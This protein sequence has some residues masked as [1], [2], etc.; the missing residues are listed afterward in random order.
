[1]IEKVEALKAEVEHEKE[2]L[3]NDIMEF[4]SY[5]QIEKWKEKVFS[6]QEELKYLRIQVQCLKV[7]KEDLQKAE[8]ESRRLKEERDYFKK[9]V[10][11]NAKRI[12]QR[13]SDKSLSSSSFLFE[14]S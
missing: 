11:E 13:K 2:R 3:K 6:Q 14:L 9:K 4:D 10:L 12:H 8:K 7:V 1:M 5:G